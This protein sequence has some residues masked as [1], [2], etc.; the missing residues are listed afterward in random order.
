MAPQRYGSI[1]PI[2]PARDGRWINDA[3]PE[4]RSGR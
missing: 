4:R 1:W 3:L 2:T